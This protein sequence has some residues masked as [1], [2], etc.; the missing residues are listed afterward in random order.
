MQS[1]IFL[2][3]KAIFHKL[4]HPRCKFQIEEWYEKYILNLLKLNQI[5]VTLSLVPGC[6]TVNY[7]YITTVWDL[8][9]RLQPY[10]PEVSISEQE[11]GQWDW[12]ENFHSKI[13]R[14]ATFIIT[15]TE[16]GKA[17]IEKFYQI[18][19]ERIKVIPFFTPKFPSEGSLIDQ[20]ILK[21]YNLPSQ[22]LF[23]PAQFWPH[24]NHIGLLLA[25][26]LLK[27]K[28]NLEFSLVF[29]GSDKGNQS[30]VKEMVQELDLSQQ[31]H[32]LGFVSQEDIAPLYRH[33]F[34]LTFMSF[35]GPDNLPPLEAMALGCPVIASN[36]S[37]AKEQL[38]DAAL[39]VNPKQPEEIA[40]A[41]KYLSEDSILRQSL[42]ERGWEKAYKWTPKDY[43]QEIFSVI[44]DF[45][46]I[47]HCWK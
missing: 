30:H 44:D 11:W 46:A 47:R 19:S 36:V 12:R 37:G 10:F 45:E 6:P 38:G 22:Y 13:L 41:I 5:D 40:E 31:V 42:I 8:Q 35:F 26:K 24:K 9:H 28:Y 3:T 2:I 43:V 21:K 33:A 16:V 25:I 1:K 20:E 4:R 23:Y 7:P 39:L 17:E 27:E 32:F 15:G 29:V 18:P 14:R 34:A